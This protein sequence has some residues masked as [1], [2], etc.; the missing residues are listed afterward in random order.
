MKFIINS[1]RGLKKA[2]KKVF[3]GNNEYEWTGTQVKLM[4]LAYALYLSG[5]IINRTKNRKASLSEI[6][7]YVF[8]MFGMTPPQNPSRVMTTLR[9]RNNPEEL[10]VMYKLLCDLYPGR[11]EIK[12]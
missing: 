7:I 10:S 1:K 6:T 3:R 5:N 9:K 4:E 2:L 8:R 12:K 11:F